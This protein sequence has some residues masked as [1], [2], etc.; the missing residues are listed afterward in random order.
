MPFFSPQGWLTLRNVSPASLAHTPPNR[1]PL[2]ASFVQSTLTPIKENLL[3]IHVILTNTQVMFGGAGY[4]GGGGTSE[5]SK[6]SRIPILLAY[7]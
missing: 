4:R 6:E 1:A 5:H 2:S 3:A 7:Y